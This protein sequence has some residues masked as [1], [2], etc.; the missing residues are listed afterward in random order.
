[1]AMRPWHLAFWCLFA[2]NAAAEP[3]VMGALGDSITAGFNAQRVGDNRELSWATGTAS[4]I[5]S[6]LKRLAVLQQQQVV[7]FNEAIAGSVAND[8][9]RQV[10]RLL[11]K[12]PDYVTLAVGAND[13]CG[14]PNDY[15]Q[16]RDAYKAQ[17]TAQIER[18]IAARPHVKIMLAPVPNMYNLW[19]VAKDHASCQTKWDMFGLCSELLGSNATDAT[20]ANFVRKWEAINTT[21]SEV[22]RDHQANVLHDPELA[23]VTFAW[24][25]LSPTDCFHPSI[26]GQNL[27]AE[28]TW[29]AYFST[30]EQAM[31][32]AVDGP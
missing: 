30:S 3:V 9:P 4:Q 23:H 5:N 32:Q 25:D 26:R 17:L 2:T 28:K 29:Q 8:L 15:D 13:V 10:T 31:A 21:I 6:H 16:V 12:N 18:V 27:L 7:G 11:A 24:E 19:S 1:M 22:A 20:R 14:W